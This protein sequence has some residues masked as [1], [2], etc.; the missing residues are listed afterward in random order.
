VRQRVAEY[1][2]VL[3]TG[4]TGTG[5][6]YLACALAQQARRKGYCAI[7]RRYSRFSAELALARLDGSHVRL[8]TKLARADVLILDDGAM[9]SPSSGSPSI[10]A[11][12]HPAGPA[13]RKTKAYS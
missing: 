10:R 4:A 3:I 7:C 5:K 9:A 2:D 6:S 12:S 1:Q 13:R 8:L 11:R